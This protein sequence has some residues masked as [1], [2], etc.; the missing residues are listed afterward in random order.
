ML[1]V[2]GMLWIIL[3]IIRHKTIMFMQLNC[4]VVKRV[5]LMILKGF[6]AMMGFPSQLKNYL[7]IKRSQWGCAFLH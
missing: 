6:V 2:W 1:I 7:K 3:L 5:I 4:V